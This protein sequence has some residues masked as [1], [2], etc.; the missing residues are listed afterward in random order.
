MSDDREIALGTG[1]P[2]E[3]SVTSR[4]RLLA[5]GA[6]FLW[7]GLATLALE[8]SALPPFLLTGIALIIGA[9]AGWGSLAGWSSLAR[10]GSP[11]SARALRIRPPP[12]GA[13]ALGAY[14]LFRF[15]FFLFLSLRDAP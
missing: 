13:P 12:A 4:P 2:I 6:I 3:P 5:L 9:L 14:R 7:G 15:P 11:A 1:A 8:L 10:W